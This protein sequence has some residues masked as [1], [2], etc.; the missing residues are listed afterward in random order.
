MDGV[1]GITQDPIQSGGNFSYEFVIDKD[2]AGTFWLDDHY[3]P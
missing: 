1:V 2:Q 3:Q